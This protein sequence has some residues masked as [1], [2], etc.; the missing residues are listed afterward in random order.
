MV[1]LLLEEPQ[2]EWALVVILGHPFFLILYGLI[3]PDLE[4]GIYSSFGVE[5]AVFV[6]LEKH[7]DS[8]QKRRGKQPGQSETHVTGAPPRAGRRRRRQREGG[9]GGAPWSG[10]PS[11][12][13][14]GR[15]T[16]V[17]L[18]LSGSGPRCCGSFPHAKHFT[19]IN[20]IN[21]NSLEHHFIFRRS[22][23]QQPP[24]GGPGRSGYQSETIEQNPF[25]STP[26]GDQPAGDAVTPKEYLV[27]L[28]VI[29]LWLCLILI[30]VRGTARWSVRRHRNAAATLATSQ[31]ID[32]GSAGDTARGLTAS[33]IH[34][35]KVFPFR[36][37]ETEQAKPGQWHQHECSVC[38]E[39]L[40]EG[41]V[42]AELPCGHVFHRECVTEWLARRPSCPICREDTGEA[43]NARA[44]TRTRGGRHG[45]GA[46]GRT[47]RGGDTGQRGERGAGVDG[48][49]ALQAETGLAGA[50]PEGRRVR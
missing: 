5:N 29:P 1:T 39:A 4:G 17:G 42:C 35:L 37:A 30:C 41:D 31:E 43:L 11:S 34:R 6:G 44:R 3:S 14:Y 10:H 24:A 47:P 2:Y 19:I 22:L 45:D 21:N 46:P 49:P 38:M 50:E 15:G 26:Y 33:Q 18:R 20:N 25:Y 40:E 8:Q 23:A 36:S 27:A 28:Y 7:H 12:A 13:W 32:E 48:Q 16:G 9:R